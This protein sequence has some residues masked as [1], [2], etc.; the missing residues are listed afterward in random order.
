MDVNDIEKKHDNE[1]LKFIREK[2][3]IPENESLRAEEINAI[4]EAV[5]QR[6]DFPIW[7]GDPLE[8][9]LSHRNE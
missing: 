9:Y 2:L 4:V 1:A 8:E 5:K 7:E 6:P 3:G